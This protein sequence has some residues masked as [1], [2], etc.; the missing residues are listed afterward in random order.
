MLALSA[1]ALAVPLAE[2]IKPV[3]TTL[4]Q[5][6]ARAEI[7]RQLF[8]D[9]RLSGNGKVL[10][11]SCHDPMKGGVDGRARSVGW[12]GQT[13][14][15]NAPTVLNA[16]LNFRQFWNGRAGSLEEQVDGVVQ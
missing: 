16:A 3:P 2:P 10:C 14:G 1:R 7:G 9:T 12:S 13:T 15:V 8:F 4:K 11:A 5:D 6:P